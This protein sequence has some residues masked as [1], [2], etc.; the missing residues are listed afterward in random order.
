MKNQKANKKAQ[1]IAVTATAVALLGAGGLWAATQT[2]SNQQSAHSASVQNKMIKPKKKTTKGKQTKKKEN[3]VN[4]VIDAALGGSE[5]DTASADHAFKKATGNDLDSNLIAGIAKALDT[6]TAKATQAAAKSV[7]EQPKAL[8][9]ADQHNTGVQPLEN[10]SS[11]SVA[12]NSNNESKPTTGKPD[13][14]GQPTTPELPAIP[15]TPTTPTTPEQP[16]NPTTPVTPEQPTTPVTPEQPTN[17]DKPTQPV[18]DEL[19]TLNV[20]TETTVS[21]SNSTTFDPMAGISASDKE[22]GDLTKAVKVQGQ[23]DLT[24]V[25]SYSLTYTVTDSA[26]HAVSVTRTVSVVNDLPV[27]K[28]TDQQVEAGTSFDPRANVTATDVQ[29]GDLT[30]DIVVIGSVDASKL[31]TYNLSYVVTDH[32]G[33]QTVKDI[34]VTVYAKDATF[35]GLNELTVNQGAVPDLRQG[36]AVSDPYNPAA[37]NYTVSDCD[38]STIGEKTVTYAYTDKWGHETTQQRLVNVVAEK[39]VF[40]GLQNQTIKLGDQFDPMAGVSATSTNG[41]VTISYVGEVNTQMAGRYTL[42]Y[43]AVDQNG[44]QTQQTIVV[45]VE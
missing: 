24:K 36:V 37:T 21:L 42:T 9:D 38:T 14:S 10:A 23:V 17:P 8:E 20:P 25:G 33:G 35:S 6:P 4:E 40:S 13:V 12:D 27:I 28:A 34:V 7:I 43:T 44:Q 31:G 26:G 16:T 18:Q 5:D 15:T 39:P 3:E 1:K 30:S 45:T 22:D 2:H 41:P 29:D 32:N 11:Q 19:P